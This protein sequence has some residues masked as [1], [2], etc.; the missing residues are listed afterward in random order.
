MQS[1]ENSDWYEGYLEQR[2]LHYFSEEQEK[3]SMLTEE[4]LPIF[5]N[6]L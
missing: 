2:E 4:N 3:E 6:K 5:S 1:A